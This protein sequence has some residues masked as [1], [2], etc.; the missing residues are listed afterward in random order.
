MT[1]KGLFITGTDTDAGKTVVTAALLRCLRE[2]LQIDAVPAKPVQT[3]ASRWPDGGKWRLPDLQECLDGAGLMPSDEEI[4]LMAPFC[5]EHPCSPHLAGR[6][7]GGAPTVAGIVAALRQLEHRHA[8]VVAEGAGGILVPLNDQ[9][10]MLDLAKA[11]KYPVVVVVRNALGC[12]NHGLLTLRTLQAAHLNV[13]GV[14][15]NTT[16][17]PTLGTDLIRRDN[18]ETIARFSGIPI[19]GVV[20]FLAPDAHGRR[21]W[22]T[23]AADAPV[24]LE[25]L[26]HLCKP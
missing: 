9:E 14:V 20:P 16:L 11:L 24:L 19:L 15:M 10:T 8:C 25:R 5:Y 22:N 4:R 18:P 26:K 2:D 3:G 21:R 13:L 6:L 1:V 17:P 12:I 7:E 23:L